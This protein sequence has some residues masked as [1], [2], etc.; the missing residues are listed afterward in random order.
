MFRAGFVTKKALA[1]WQDIPSFLPVFQFHEKHS[2]VIRTSYP[3][4]ILPCIAEFDMHQDPVIR[5]LMSV[6]QLLCSWQA[7]T[8]EHAMSTR[9]AGLE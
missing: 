8:R 4:K 1:E 7:I 6:R 3:N 2:A 9:P 5:A